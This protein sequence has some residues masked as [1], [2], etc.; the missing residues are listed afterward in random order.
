MRS[1]IA[2]AFGKVSKPKGDLQ[3]AEKKA[4]AVEDLRE[5]ILSPSVS[6]AKKR[7]Y[8]GFIWFY[9]VFIRGFQGSRA[10]DGGFEDT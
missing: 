4:E 6:L 1:L 3:G 5:K 10:V 9:M 7:F 2:G 8:T